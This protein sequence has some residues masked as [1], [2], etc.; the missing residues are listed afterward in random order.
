M[1]PYEQ[2]YEKG[3]GGGGTKGE[4]LDKGRTIIID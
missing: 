1:Y 4:D 2:F 3:G